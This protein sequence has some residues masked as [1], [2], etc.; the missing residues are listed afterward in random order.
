MYDY[1]QDFVRKAARISRE[2]RNYP[3]SKP[4]KVIIEFNRAPDKESWLLYNGVTSRTSEE[5]YFDKLDRLQNEKLRKDL[6][7]SIDR[8]RTRLENLLDEY[9]KLDPK[10]DEYIFDVYVD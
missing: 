10:E 8:T 9:D 1:N 3:F 2:L 7:N 4:K 6:V 5:N